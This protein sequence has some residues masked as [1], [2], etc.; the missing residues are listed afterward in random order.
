M[1][2]A[3]RYETQSSNQWVENVNDLVNQIGFVQ[4]N[5]ETY[6]QKDLVKNSVEYA[7]DL[8][9]YLQMVKHVK[10]TMVEYCEHKQRNLIEET[11]F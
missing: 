9:N 2:P 3:K 4:C 6:L 5:R 1:V 11:S 10:L 7:V 8:E